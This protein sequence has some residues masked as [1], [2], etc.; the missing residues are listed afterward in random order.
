MTQLEYQ[1][2]HKNATLQEL[3]SDLLRLE[4]DI[5]SQNQGGILFGIKFIAILLGLGLGLSGLNRLLERLDVETFALLAVGSVALWFLFKDHRTR[6]DFDARRR[7][8]EYHIN[9]KQSR[10]L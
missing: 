2:V 9:N 3:N 8:I 1:E 4:A 6:Q 5:K 10:R 7:A